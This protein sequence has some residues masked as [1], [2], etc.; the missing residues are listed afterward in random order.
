[1]EFVLFFN[2]EVFGE[3]NLFFKDINYKVVSLRKAFKDIKTIL[4]MVEKILSGMRP[5]GRLHIG[6]IVGALDNWVKLQEEGNETFYFVADWHALTTQTDTRNMKS[7]TIEMVKDWL[8]AGID[9]NK[10]TLFIQSEVPQHAELGLILERLINLGRAERVPTFKGYAAQILKKNY[11]DGNEEEL[12]FSSGEMA[13]AKGQISL[14]FLAY[15]ILQAADVLLYNTT[16][17]PVGEDQIPHIELTKELARRFNGIY[18]PVF[19]IPEY[20]LTQSPKILGTDG[21]KMSKSLGNVIS[22]TE[23]LE[24]LIRLVKK[25]R[26]DS[27]RQSVTI[28]GD[29]EKCDVYDLHYAFNVQ[30][31][32][33]LDVAHE[34]KTADRG[35]GDCKIEAAQSVFNRFRDYKQRREEFEGKEDLILEILSEGSSKARRVASETIKRVKEHMLL[36]YG[37][38]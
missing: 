26:I 33:Y 35:C 19:T 22:P 23:N 27:A 29:P 18:G 36:D 8:A 4:F 3:L 13:E 12:N 24:T 16:M 32:A 14:G 9:P 30:N 11:Q 15:P 21:R 25:M 34:C 2:F 38:K 10:S 31:N 17:V 1:L 20:S 28:P 37:S 6:H 5:T 7:D